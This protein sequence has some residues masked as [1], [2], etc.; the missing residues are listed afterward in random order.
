MAKKVKARK[1]KM[2]LWQDLVYM[3][4]VAAR[5]IDLTQ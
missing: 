4:L 3:A 1:L 5:L 2:P